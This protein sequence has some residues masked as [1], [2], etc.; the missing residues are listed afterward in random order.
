MSIKMVKGKVRCRDYKTR[1]G[2][3]VGLGGQKE[4]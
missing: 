1:R 3:K 2:T 4:F